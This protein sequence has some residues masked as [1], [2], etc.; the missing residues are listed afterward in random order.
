MNDDACSRCHD[1]AGQLAE[2]RQLAMSLL[3]R[4]AEIREALGVGDE[5]GLDELPAIAKKMNKAYNEKDSPK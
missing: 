2:E 5:P 1:L 4:M 3:L